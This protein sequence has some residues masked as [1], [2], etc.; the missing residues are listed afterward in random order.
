MN[1]KKW[2]AVSAVITAVAVTSVRAADVTNTF[3]TVADFVIVEQGAN[4]LHYA[5]HTWDGSNLVALALG[6]EPTSNQVFAMDID[7]D[8]TVAHLD[9]FDKSN[10]NRTIIATS[11]SF[12]VVERQA[13]HRTRHHET[14][15][16]ATN[17]ERFVAEFVTEHVGDILANGYLTVAGRL[18]LGTNGCPTTVSV[19]LDH[20]SDDS[21]FDDRDVTDSEQDWKVSDQLRAGQGHFTGVLDYVNGGPTNT[22]LIPLGHLSFRHELE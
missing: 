20:D 3:R 7:C 12:D 21:L 1:V 4:P 2:T 18:H 22:A 9:V 11:T 15:F 14:V 6:A 5:E 10:S 16:G 17:E 13:V 8:S 19:G